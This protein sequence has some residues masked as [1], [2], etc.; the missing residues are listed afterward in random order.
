LNYDG[1]CTARHVRFGAYKISGRWIFVR[2]SVPNLINFMIL[3][4]N[5]FGV[6]AVSAGPNTPM[7]HRTILSTLSRF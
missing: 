3:Q 6:T 7:F 1:N 4:Q 5:L 2:Q